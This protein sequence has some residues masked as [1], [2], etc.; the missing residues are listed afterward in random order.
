LRGSL[1]QAASFLF[2]ILVFAAFVRRGKPKT[3]PRVHAVRAERPALS[4]THRRLKYAN[5]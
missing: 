4:T 5:A 1:L 3:Q 2:F